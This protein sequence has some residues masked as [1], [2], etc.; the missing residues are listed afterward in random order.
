LT[1]RFSNMQPFFGEIYKS[2]HKQ[3]D[4]ISQSAR[5]RSG[6]IYQSAR[7]HS[8]EIYQNAR[9]HPGLTVGSAATAVAA[10]GLGIGLSVGSSPAVSAATVPTAV[11]AAAQAHQVASAASH[12]G[13]S[14]VHT[15]PSSLPASTTHHTAVTVRAVRTAEPS[16]ATSSPQAAP[17][18]P[19]L[20]YDSTTPTAIPAHHE[21]ATYATGPFAVPAS[22]VAGRNVMWIDTNGSDPQAGALDIEPGDATPQVAATWTREKLSADPH[23]VAVLYT[24]QSEW[25]SVQQAVGQL[26]SW[27]QHQVRW[28]IADPTGYPHVLPGANAT[29]WYWGQNYDIS[30][31]N[32]GFQPNP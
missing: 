11:H 32:P 30:T 16:R 6:Q 21:V 9:Q 14:S 15:A 4:L 24:M 27:M 7:Q 26:P 12:A 31:A 2:A 3:Y 23:T 8:G 18:K 13:T 25:P 17:P 10:A 19:Y 28:W 1:P 29:Q 22:Q 5:Q 20:I